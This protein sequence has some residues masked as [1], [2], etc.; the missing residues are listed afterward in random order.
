MWQFF[1]RMRLKWYYFSKMSFHVIC[2]VFSAE[3]QK[4]FNVGKIRKYDEETEY[5]EKKTLSSF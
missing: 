4:V 2:E 5:F 3:N 1:C